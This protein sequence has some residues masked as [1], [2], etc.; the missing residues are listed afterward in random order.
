M[1][2]MSPDPGGGLRLVNGTITSL[3]ST[4]YPGLPN[5]EG[6]PDWARSERYD[7]IAKA[8]LGR[9]ATTE[10]RRAMMRAFLRRAHRWT[11]S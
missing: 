2:T 6:L 1:V 3:I 7:V 5:P 11:Y 4:A 10:D 8:A 9:V